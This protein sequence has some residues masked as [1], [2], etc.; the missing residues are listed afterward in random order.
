MRIIH[1]IE[2]INYEETEVF[3]KNRSKKYKENSPYSVTMYQD[4]NPNLVQKRNETELKK[5]LPLLQINESCKFLDLACG[6][7]RWAEQIKEK[8][9]CYYGIDFSRDFI[10]IAKKRN[11]QPQNKFIA[12]QLTQL[13]QVISKGIKFN[14]IL[15]IG[16]CPYINDEDVSTML[17]DTEQHCEEKCTICIREPI[18]INDRLTL[19]SFFSDEL[20]DTYN[21][22]YRTRTEFLNFFSESLFSRGFHIDYE[23]FLF[24][25][26]LNNRK[27]TAQ[28]YF[29]L[30]R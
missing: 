20:N 30:K 13:N 8:Y 9:E 12:A 1:N 17:K 19:K 16:A 4:N 21:A 11:P 23:G 18:A 15:I 28:Y 29:I 7:G 5:L 3:F 22:I 6:I 14:R 10:E 24:E 26:A 25:D 27:E 2:K